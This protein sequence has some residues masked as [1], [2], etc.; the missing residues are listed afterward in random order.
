MMLRTVALTLTGA[1]LAL[2]QTQSA[3]NIC[4][5]ATSLDCT[6]LAPGTRVQVT[7]NSFRIPRNCFGVDSPVLHLR[8]LETSYEAEL[9]IL[10]RGDLPCGAIAHSIL[11]MDLPLGK[12][13]I[14]LRA[15]DNYGPAA[16]DIV[17][18]HFGI[19][20]VADIGL[21]HPAQPGSLLRIT[22]TGLGRA[23]PADLAATL[24]GVDIEIID[25][26]T[27]AAS[28]IDEIQVR[29]PVYFPQESC[30]VPL[31]VHVAG[32]SSNAIMIPVSQQP[33]AC[34]HPLDLTATQLA[35]LDAGRS[36]PISFVQG[37]AAQ[38][39]LIG[40]QALERLLTPPAMGCQSESPSASIDPPTRLDTILHAGP[41]VRLE[42]IDGTREWIFETAA[43]KDV[44]PVSARFHV[45]ETPVIS[46]EAGQ[47][48]W[49]P[50][51][52]D[53]FDVVRVLITSRADPS[54]R[55]LCTA[56]ALDGKLGLPPLP[57]RPLIFDI[58][59]QRAP[60]HPQTFEFTL[61]NGAAG[62]GLILT[63]VYQQRQWSPPEMP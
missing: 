10:R 4:N 28:G 51:P 47:I 21:S 58:V 33:D 20:G 8:S 37:S 32:E 38:F 60:Q 41:I 7:T 48:T 49:N 53:S 45:P 43:G 39:G 6:R 17:A 19:A 59:A 36:L 26:T 11:P 9:P 46:L 55:V 1:F 35:I 54:L 50:D 13:E 27:T 24:G 5:T 56:A 52:Y 18:T 25:V 14:T 63:Q 44:L 34:P 62:A 40:R 42:S 31:R 15:D 57:S 29:I 16:V 30:Y 3:L 23:V 22:G 61:V 2:A 12:A